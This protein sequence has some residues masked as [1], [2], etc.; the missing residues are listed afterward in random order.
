MKIRGFA[1]A[2][3]V[4]IWCPKYCPLDTTGTMAYIVTQRPTNVVGQ[5]IGKPMSSPSDDMAIASVSGVW[6]VIS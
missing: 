6:V 4:H 3:T 5:L 1:R 2:R